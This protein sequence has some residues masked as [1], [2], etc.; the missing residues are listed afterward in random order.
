M[1]TSPL[2]IIEE[3]V[4]RETLTRHGTV[5]MSFL[6]TSRYNVE[7]IERG[8]GGWRLTEVPVAKPW[9]KNYDEGRGQP[10]G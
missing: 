5:P 3:P 6:V 9:V 7:M 2:K 8:L 4:N 1:K 10:A